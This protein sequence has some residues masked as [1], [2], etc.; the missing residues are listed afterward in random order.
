MRHS[1]SIT[2]LDNAEAPLAATSNTSHNVDLKSLTRQ[3]YLPV[4][5]R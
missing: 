1:S 5:M 3:T 4:T 2:A